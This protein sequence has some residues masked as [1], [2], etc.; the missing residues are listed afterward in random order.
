MPTLTINNKSYTIEPGANLE[1][2]NLRDANLEG[3]NLRDANLEG[4]NL[5]GAN[6]E[7]ANLRGANLPTG[8]TWKQYLEQ[9]A[10]AY[11]TAGGKSLKEAPADIWG[12]HSWDNCP[13]AWA[14]DCHD[15]A[16]VPLL[17]RPRA[18]QFIQLWDAGL[19]RYQDGQFVPT[20]EG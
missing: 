19:L 8:E 10:P 17:L 3:A 15:L 4:A 20:K 6:L 13:T 9:V 14:F 5:S 18:Q 1:G 12:C 2:A 16:G 11:L 7:D